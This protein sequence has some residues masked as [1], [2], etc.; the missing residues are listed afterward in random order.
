MASL[1]G[2]IASNKRKTALLV[3]FF[4][5]FIMALGGFLGQ[6]YDIVW[7]LPAAV[8]FSLVQALI[9]YYQSDKIVLSISGAKEPPRKEPYIA[10]HRIVENLAITAGL[11]KPKIYL[12]DDTA[13]NAFATG[14]DPNHASI[15]VTKGLLIKLNKN[16]LQGVIGHELA[17]I[18][19]YDI[20]LMTMVVVLVGIVSLIAD[21]S[22]RSLWIGSNSDNRRGEAG[23]VL[24]VVSLIALILAP[25]GAT[26]IQLA[27]SRKREFLADA[28]GVM[29]T[30]YPEGLISALEKINRDKE[31]LEVAN[32]ATAHL[33]IENPLKAHQGRDSIGWLAN[34]FSTHPAVSERIKRLERAV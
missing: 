25:I 29:L 4:L 13:P 32:R 26:L 8:I 23:P 15:A 11:P 22:L 5:V 31:P 2:E 17:H 27:V 24:L 16:E 21:W 20:R 9:A 6:V 33:Y 19:N 1:Y 28:S 7:L 10:L 30:R 14:R 12:I 34:L 18:G 3:G